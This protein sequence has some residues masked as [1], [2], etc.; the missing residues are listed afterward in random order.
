MASPE[1][2]SLLVGARELIAASWTQHADARDAAGVAINP[3][4]PDAVSWSL[5]GALVN[6]YERLL[7]S[8]GQTAA[9]TQLAA[10]CVLLADL[11]DSHSLAAWNDAPARTQTDVLDLL[12][13]AL[14]RA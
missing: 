14:T 10:A 3:W 9:L 8:E 2:D 7:W 12:D 6:G 13:Q 1:A 11:V 4:E 5:L